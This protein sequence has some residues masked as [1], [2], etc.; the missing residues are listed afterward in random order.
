MRRAGDLRSRCARSLNTAE[1]AIEHRHRPGPWPALRVRLRPAAGTGDRAALGIWVLTRLAL[2][3]PIAWSL[4]LDALARLPQSWFHWDAVLFTDIARYG[5]DGA[6]GRPHGDPA[7]PS[8]LVAFF[9]GLPLIL[10]TV[11]VV[12]PDWSTAALAVSAAAGAV[13]AVA[14]SRLAD[15]DGPPGSGPRAVLALAAC[16][17]AVFLFAGYSEALFLACALPAWLLARRG[18]W[19]PSALCAAAASAVRVTGLFLAVALVV[20][21]LADREGARGRGGWRQAPWLL[22]PFAPIVAYMLFLWRRAGDPL[23][24]LHAEENW[25]SRHFAWPWDSFANTFA[26]AIDPHYAYVA[27][28]RMELLAM[29]A[30]VGLVGWL[31]AGRRWA[32]STYIGLQLTAL[33]TSAYYQAIGR[34][35][36]LWW[37]L[38][39]LIGAAGVRRPW[40]YLAFVTVAG[41][42]MV[43][44]ALT[45]TSGRWAG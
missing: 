40:R 20:E 16:P 22:V 18:R 31:L 3:V 1:T 2:A 21:F 11:H 43:R 5:Y 37:P 44:F 23:A 29:L 25:P 4:P 24:W 26:K 39:L 27:A 34:A 17:S 45:F 13:A 9:P 28:T 14:L 8:S 41:A 42:L 30:G 12:I 19:A 35:A 7:E 10:R 15:L 36:L 38:W 32:E 6:P 33:G